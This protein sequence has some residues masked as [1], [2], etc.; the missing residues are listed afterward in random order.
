[1]PRDISRASSSSPLSRSSR[2]G[3]SWSRW[4]AAGC[5]AP[6][7]RWRSPARATRTP[8][9]VDATDLRGGWEWVARAGPA[10]AALLMPG[11]FFLSSMG[12][13][14]AEPNRAVVLVYAGGALLALGLAVLGVGLLMA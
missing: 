9:F 8:P 13:G 14:R 10:V 12:P 5:R 4:C 11:G 3:C 7:S 1:M 6:P 2:A